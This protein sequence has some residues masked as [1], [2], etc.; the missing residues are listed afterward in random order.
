[1]DINSCSSFFGGGG[2]G[3]DR[4]GACCG[5]VRFGFFEPPIEGI[6]QWNLLGFV[7][8]TCEDRDCDEQGSYE[9]HIVNL[10]C[11]SGAEED[12]KCQWDWDFG[13]AQVLSKSTPLAYKGVRVYLRYT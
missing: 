4:R 10:L 5:K 8:C 2:G 1:M 6:G 9:A 13:I 3:R 12:K 7:R 11:Y